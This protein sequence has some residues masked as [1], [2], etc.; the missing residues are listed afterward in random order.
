MDGHFLY[1]FCDPGANPGDGGCTKETCA[2]CGISKKA[3]KLTTKCSGRNVAQ[4]QKAMKRNKKLIKELG[5]EVAKALST[6][7]PRDVRKATVL[8]PGW[9]LGTVALPAAARTMQG[10]AAL[11][12]GVVAAANKA[13]QKRE[14]RKLTFEEAR[15]IQAGLDPVTATAPR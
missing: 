11:G 12:I 14:G 1:R 4:E 10:E 7:Q 9:L 13:M 2:R 3:A 15:R 5:Q 8:Q 6:G